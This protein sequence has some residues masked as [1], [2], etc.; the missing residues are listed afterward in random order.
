MAIPDP[1]ACDLALARLREGQ[2][3]AAVL[4]ALRKLGL[5]E[6]GAARALQRARAAWLQETLPGALRAAG[7]R[8][9]AIG[10]VLSILSL[11]LCAFAGWFLYSYYSSGAS[12]EYTG[13]RSPLAIVGAVVTSLVFSLGEIAWAASRFRLARRKEAERREASGGA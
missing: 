13:F 5:P 6:A 2:S 4:A 10:I 8:H 3:P 12:E 1:E 11:G 7:R 9:L